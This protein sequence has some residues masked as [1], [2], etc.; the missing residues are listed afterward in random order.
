MSERPHDPPPPEAPRSDAPAELSWAPGWWRTAAYAT[1]GLA[2]AAV[3]LVEDLAWR[4]AELDS[5]GR[6]LVGVC[7]AGLIALAVRDALARPALRVRPEGI[8][9]VDGV[10][11]GG[12]GRRHLPWAAVFEIRAG[13]LRHNRRLVHIRTLEIE[14]IDG[15]VLLSRRQL[16]TDPE[17][18]AEAVEELRIR[19]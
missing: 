19:L 1:A 6:L 16:G 14:T 5:A 17:K 18:V 2:L 13:T 9:Y 8:D 12:I 4:L 10:G 15:P 3:A 11:I 7:A